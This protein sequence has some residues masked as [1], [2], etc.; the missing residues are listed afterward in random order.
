MVHTFTLRSRKPGI[1]C[2]TCNIVNCA[3][4]I[5]HRSGCCKAHTPAPEELRPHRRYQPA[6]TRQVPAAA[7]HRR[8]LAKR[9]AVRP[10][11][12][13]HWQ[14]P[15][16]AVKPTAPHTS[17]HVRHSE[18]KLRNRVAWECSG[19]AALQRLACRARHAQHAAPAPVTRRLL[20]S[21]GRTRWP[22]RAGNAVSDADG[23]VP[24]GV[25]FV[26]RQRLWR[27]CKAVQARAARLVRARSSSLASSCMY[28]HDV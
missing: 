16:S 11:Q 12:R 18:W 5:A 24:G 14:R 17:E 8:Q 22:G 1:C 20:A 9:I 25:P 15:E 6:S 7:P 27:D 23:A 3:G 28:M 2:A 10:G 21:V 19:T 26:D 4:H 13:H